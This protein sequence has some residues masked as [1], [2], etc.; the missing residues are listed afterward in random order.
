[1]EWVLW[2]G[3]VGFDSDLDDRM[4]AAASNGYSM[5]SL[6]P[7][8]VDTATRHGV[9]ARELRHRAE[10]RGLTWVMDPIMNWHP[11]HKPSRLIH[12]MFSVEAVL[13]MCNELGAPSVSPIAASHTAE[14]DQLVEHFAR[15]CDMAADVGVRCHL[16]FMPMSAIPDLRTAWDIVRSADRPNGGLMFDT[17]HFFR[18]DPD[19]DLLATIP[20]DRIFAV[21]FDDA[22]S[23]VAGSL[24]DDTSNRL[25][26]GDGSFDLPRVIEVLDRV[27]GLEV[28]G[29][30]VINPSSAS[31]PAVELA[32]VARERVEA[33][34]RRRSR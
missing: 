3:T 4:E 9:T 7:H 1:M 25:L 11:V 30:E 17:W 32:R 5:V 23:D 18:S 27:G 31:V 22:A 6:G 34:L 8:D 16:E 14:P 28:I 26:P 2:A 19:F 15:L 10:D 29:P 12:A 24:W 20:G 21:Q 33:L 13:G